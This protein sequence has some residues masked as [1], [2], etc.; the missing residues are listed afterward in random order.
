MLGTVIT[1]LL[2]FSAGIATGL[3]V[4]YRIGK[5][6]DEKEREEGLEE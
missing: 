2:I 6:I 3:F 5:D 4:L 1:H